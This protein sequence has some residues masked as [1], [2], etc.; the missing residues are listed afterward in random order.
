MFEREERSGEEKKGRDVGEERREMRAV[1]V[2][3]MRKMRAIP[4]NQ[5]FFMVG[6]MLCVCLFFFFFFFFFFLFS[7]FL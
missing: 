3:K 7:F 2:K 5:C 1:L 6:F 4:M